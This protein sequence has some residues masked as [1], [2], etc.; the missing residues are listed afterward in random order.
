MNIKICL[1]MTL[2]ISEAFCILG[3][4]P[5]DVFMAPGV[6][7]SKINKKNT[8]KNDEKII[9][10]IESTDPN[11]YNSSKL[12]ELEEAQEYKSQ[13]PKEMQQE[14]NFKSMVTE[15]EHSDDN[16]IDSYDDITVPRGLF[17]ES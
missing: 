2:F 9:E 7:D 16:N 17:F 1:L 14:F 8:E 11:K 12:S 5:S 15:E 13:S 3:P 4:D 10:G 6:F